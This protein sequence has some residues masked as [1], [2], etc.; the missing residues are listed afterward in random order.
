MTSENA[1]V[2]ICGAGLAGVSAAY[3]LS[4]KH[5]LGNVLLIDER[6]PLSLTSDH[7]TECYRNWWPDP[8]MV[9]FMNRSIDLLDQLAEESG[10]LFHLNRRGYLY[11][12]GEESKIDGFIKQAEAISRI[13]G[14]PLRIHDQQYQSV[15]YSPSILKNQF[16]QSA[17]AD[18]LLGSNLI[19]SHFPFMTPE[20]RVALHVRRAGWLSAQQLGMYL[21]DQA[22]ISGVRMIN[23]RVIGIDTSQ[24]GVSGVILENGRHIQTR[25][26]VNAAGPFIN[27]VCGMLGIDLPVYHELHLKLAIKDAFGVLSRHAPLVIWNDPQLLKWTDEEQSLLAEEPH[28][29]KL[30]GLLPSGIHTRPEGGSDSQ[31]I[32]VLWEYQTHLSEPIFPIAEDPMYSEVC[33]RG[34]TRPIPGMQVYVERMP[35]PRLDGGYYTRTRENRPL[36]C[37]LPIGGAYLIGALSG[38]GVMAACA[39]GELLAKLVC[40]E[41]LPDFAPAFDLKR[42]QDSEYLQSIEEMDLSGQL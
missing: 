19:R 3:F 22:R 12:S 42:Y 25:K 31:M 15:R 37:K 5:G 36:I 20:T 39:A 35:K 34:L 29:S 41:K 17:G 13:G 38:F 14:G 30:S 9:A 24:E 32:L 27:E 23:T 1:N 7:S 33:L 26:F 11:C 10:N 2:V 28:A 40:N 18:L 6:P 8:T 4:V 16:N 21:L